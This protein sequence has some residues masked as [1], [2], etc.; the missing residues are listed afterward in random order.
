MNFRAFASSSAGNLYAVEFEGARLLIDPGVR[1]KDLQRAL[2]FKASASVGALVSHSH[3]DHSEAVPGLLRSAVRVYAT[4]GTLAALAAS[5]HH[6][7]VE[8]RP[9]ERF[10]VGPFK[11]LPFPTRHDAEGAV[12]FLIGSP[13]GDC[14]LYAIDTAYVPYRF[15]GLTHVAIEANFSEVLLRR[16]EAPPEQRR[17]ILKNHMSVERAIKALKSNDLSHVREIHLLHLSDRHGDA[18]AFRLEVERAT[19]RPTYVAPRDLNRSG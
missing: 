15:A 4:A 5:H 6:G 19:G 14:L 17:R 18:E 3:G 2:G 12:G 11:V 16:S 10:R 9:M 7:A 13:D 1:M 8:I